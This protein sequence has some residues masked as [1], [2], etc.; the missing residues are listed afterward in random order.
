MTRKAGPGRPRTPMHQRFWAKVDKTDSCWNWTGA[1]S[2]Y[3]YGRI[4]LD[5][6]QTL[7]HRYSWELH[8]QEPLAGRQLD[9][10]C[11]NKMCVN[12]RHLRIVTQAQNN[13]NW[14]G[15]QQRNPTGVRGVHL[16]GVKT[17]RGRPYK[18]EATLDGVTYYGGR[19][20]TLE[21]AAEAARQL[22]LS[23]F[24][25]NDADRRSAC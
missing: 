4:G 11:H 18:V 8:K 5:G 19:F 22:R 13:Q 17:R 24:T 1:P 25:H 15:A 2:Q 10:I 23:L 3:G 14:Q 9:H 21:E 16:T 12:P 6:V 20:R 7:A